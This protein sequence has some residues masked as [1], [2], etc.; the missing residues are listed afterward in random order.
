MRRTAINLLIVWLAAVIYS[1]R[2]LIEFLASGE[3]EDFELKLDQDDH[4]YHHIELEL[5]NDDH[6]Y[7]HF[8]LELD[9]DDHHYHQ[10]HSDDHDDD[11][12]DDDDDECI[13][14][15]ETDLDDIAVRGVD[16]CLLYVVPIAIQIFCYVRVARKLWS[17]QVHVLIQYENVT[18]LAASSNE[19]GSH[20]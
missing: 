1:A 2:I 6:Q 7:H 13:L 16:L 17:S 12:D 8:E 19:S 10:D 11:D 15:I 18:F 14:F 3:R 9:R 4:Q 20:M 5:N